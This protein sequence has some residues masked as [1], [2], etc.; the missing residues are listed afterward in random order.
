MEYYHAVASREAF[1]LQ[2]DITRVRRPSLSPNSNPRYSTQ[3]VRR[4]P[5]QCVLKDI[6]LGRKRDTIEQGTKRPEILLIIGCGLTRERIECAGI[7][8]AIIALHTFLE[9]YPTTEPYRLTVPEVHA[10]PG[11][12]RWPQPWKAFFVRPC[13]VGGGRLYP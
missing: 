9:Y 13:N 3:L 4:E 6:Q 5:S 1:T 12:P 8:N 7:I 11:A 10:M 2:E